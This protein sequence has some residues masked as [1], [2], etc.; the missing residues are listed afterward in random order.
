VTK[1]RWAVLKYPDG[2][3]VR[4][5]VQEQEFYP[6]LTRL[7]MVYGVKYRIGPSCAEDIETALAAIERQH[8][9]VGRRIAGAR[10]LSPDFGRGSGGPI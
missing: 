3:K 2:R 1:Y 7:A 5:I 8:R 9:L 10:P 6:E 4:T